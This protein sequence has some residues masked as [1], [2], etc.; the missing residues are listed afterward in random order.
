M[1]RNI[2]ILFLAQSIFWLCTFTGISFASLVGAQLT[3]IKELSTLP[4]AMQV[5]TTLI[6]TKILSI[7]MRRLGRTAPLVIGSMSGC[8][9]SLIAAYGIYKINFPI[10]CAGVAFIGIFTASSAYYRHTALDSIEDQLKGKITS[11]II[12][13]GLLG[14]LIGPYITHGTKNIFSIPYLGSYI[15]IALFSLTNAILLC[16]LKRNNISSKSNIKNNFKYS[17]TSLS[18]IF[19]TATG[20]GLM[21]L[22]MNATPLAMQYCGFNTE[23]SVQ[24]IQWHVIAMF[25]P[26][27]F[28]SQLISKF[29]AYSVARSGLVILLIS[30]GLGASSTSYLNFTLSTIFLGIGW[31]LL[32]SSGT[33]LLNTSLS[34]D[35]KIQGQSTME[36]S[37]GL[38]A[39]LM[40][41]L[42]GAL[43]Q[44]IGWETVNIFMIPFILFTLIYTWQTDREKISYG[45]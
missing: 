1:Q 19:F 18:A 41:F 39:V 7:L 40:S 4:L 13:G 21:I 29:S 32:I 14:A 20:H 3:P 2:P 38:A 44:T 45:T 30:I 33:V 27:F 43:L 17:K 12:S 5:L 28:T 34:D 31:N 26:S 36:I 9:G 16:F 35:R 22:G 23:Q 10:F 6:S 25:A 37:N 24:T 8:L 11:I 15:T 42:S